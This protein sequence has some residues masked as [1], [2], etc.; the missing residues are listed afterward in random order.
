MTGTVR[1]AQVLANGK[2]QKIFR[3]G[4]RIKTV[5]S[6]AVTPELAAP[7]QGGSGCSINREGWNMKFRPKVVRRILILM[8]YVGLAILH[9]HVGIAALLCYVMVFT[10]YAMEV[11][12]ETSR[13]TDKSE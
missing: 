5:N 10:G 2:W 6:G 1:R 8:G 4:G 3:T 9:F 11:W 13:P 7:N 12:M